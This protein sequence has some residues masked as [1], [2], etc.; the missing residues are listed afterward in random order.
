MGRTCCVPW[1][2][3]GQDFVRG[4][5]ASFF[6]FPKDEGIHKK[7]VDFVAGGSA[8]TPNK[9]SVIC[10]DHFSSDMMIQG[11]NRLDKK[12]NAFPGIYFAFLSKF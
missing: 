11:K 7:W 1:C 6:T 10:S 4:G 5:G 9:S 12:K 3:N 8:W 2:T